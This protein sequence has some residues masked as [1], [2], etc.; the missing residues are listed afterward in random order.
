MGPAI[1]VITVLGAS[2]ASAA[3]QTSGQPIRLSAWAVNMSNVATGSNAVL[4]IRVDKWST[5]QEKEA[6]ISA[7]LDKGQDGLLRALQKVPVKGRIRIPG[8]QG[9]DPSQTRLGWDLRFAMQWAGEDGGQRILVATDR[10]M[11]F[12]EVKN[13]P[14]TV[15]YPFT[16]AEIHLNK[17][18]EGEGK[19][20]VATQ[21][22]FDKKKNT[23]VFENYSTEP[24]RLQQVKV[25]K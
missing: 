14:R 21:L 6:L 8:K 2:G 16:F 11:T 5:E 20:A 3:A 10:F 7:F 13:R 19:L 12:Q 4:D 9:A 15:D 24:V 18:G 23:I 22:M 25:Q 17:D 1:V